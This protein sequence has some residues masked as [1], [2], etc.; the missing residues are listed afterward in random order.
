MPPD[1]AAEVMGQLKWEKGASTT[2]RRVCK[3]WRDVHDQRL[4][5]L[6]VADCRL[7]SA[8]LSR[9]VSRFVRRVWEIVSVDGDTLH[10]A[11]DTITSVGGSGDEEWLWALAGLTSL[12]GISLER[13]PRRV[14]DDGL[15]AVAGLTD[16]TDLKLE[17]CRRVSDDGLD[18]GAGHGPSLPSPPSTCLDVTKSQTTG[19]GH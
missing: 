17:N 4:R 16:L 9:S 15:R 13:C 11:I 14:S 2:F 3:G 5:Q 1:V 19:C 10:P 18:R 8:E 7:N 6:S 12:T